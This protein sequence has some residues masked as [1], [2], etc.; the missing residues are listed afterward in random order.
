[1]AD[2][3]HYI[4]SNNNDIPY[5]E[6]RGFVLL[7]LNH[8]RLKSDADPSGMVH[9][10]MTS[11][12]QYKEFLPTLRYGSLSEF[13]HTRRAHF[14]VIAYTDPIRLHRLKPNT[15]GSLIHVHDQLLILDQHLRY[16]SRSCIR[17]I[18]LQ[19]YR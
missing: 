4:A 11:H 19:H 17:H 7:I 5:I 6:S 1:M 2:T 12:E 13:I 15:H 3:S 18:M 10:I 14:N 9:G 8:L 16:D